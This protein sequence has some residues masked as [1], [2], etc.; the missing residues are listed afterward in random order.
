MQQRG[1][2][3]LVSSPLFFA[4][5]VGVLCGAPGAAQE[6]P[7]YDFQVSSMVTPPDHPAHNHAR[8]SDVAFN[9]VN[10]EYFVVWEGELGLSEP[11]ETEIFGRRILAATGQTL[12]SQIRIS[13]MGPDG[14][15]DYTVGDPA[16][17]YVAR[18][19]RYFVVWTAENDTDQ[20][21]G[22]FEIFGQFV[23]GGTDSL[24]GS[25][26]RI[27]DHGPAGSSSWDAFSPDIAYSASDYYLFVVWT[28]DST[29]PGHHEIFGQLLSPTGVMYTSSIKISD[30]FPAGDL[31]HNA[32][33]PAVAR[34]DCGV[35][36]DCF[37]GWMVVWEGDDSSQTS[38]LENE[39]FAQM[40][41]KDS[42]F[43]VQSDDIRMSHV[44]TDGDADRDAQDASVSFN[45]VDHEF[46]IVW[47][48]DHILDGMN[49]IQG[50]RLEW[51]SPGSGWTPS[52]QFTI[53]DMG[54][55]SSPDYVAHLPAMAFDGWRNGYLVT[56][57]G[58]DDRPGQALYEFEIFAR[59]LDN[60]GTPIG[61]SIRVSTS[62]PAMDP[63]YDAWRPSLAFNYDDSSRQYLIVWES[64]E[65]KYDSV[66]GFFYD[67][68]EI[69][70]QRLDGWIFIDGFESGD[71]SGWSFADP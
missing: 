16:I 37:N 8:R 62:G 58:L 69:F 20:V 2:L 9:P 38:D 39:I 51:M 53:S 60:L 55:G 65:R 6:L 32:E 23:D 47:S 45:D 29:T 40:V 61:G 28:G 59:Q 4:A 71:T 3:T 46:L 41:T 34:A 52:S 24:W 57:A 66:G 63:D 13:H 18:D 27:T 12:G 30:M 26:I 68:Y 22:E 56:W 17:A 11:Y 14:D 25:R 35:A 33:S 21:Q 1:I 67:D 15:S 43:L 31:G 19:N 44:G 36:P 49:E 54:S 10:G 7:P 42:S 5:C 50:A 70:G 64:L 48:G